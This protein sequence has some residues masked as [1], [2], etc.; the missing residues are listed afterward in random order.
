MSNFDFLKPEFK[1]FYPNA[2]QAEKLALADPRGSCFYARLTLEMAVHWLYDHDRT[3][4]RPYEQMLGALIHEPTFQQLLPPPL[5][6][7]I[8]AIQKAGNQAAHNPKPVMAYDSVRICRELF[9]LL[10]WLART[11]T[12]LSDP[13][14]LDVSFNPELAQTPAHQST[15]PSRPIHD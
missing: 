14:D 8:K 7:K 9:H 10:Y 13:K 1:R 3:L 11:Y 5:F 15:N 6:N 2:S 12:R 4:R